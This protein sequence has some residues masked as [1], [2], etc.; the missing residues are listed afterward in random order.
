MAQKNILAKEANNISIDLDFDE[1]LFIDLINYKSSDTTQNVKANI[2]Q[3][4]NNLLFMKI[5]KCKER[6][7]KYK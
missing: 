4:E 5:R 3:K 7:T 2:V 6:K 1:T